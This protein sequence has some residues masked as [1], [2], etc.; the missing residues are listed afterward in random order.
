M[1]GAQYNKTQDNLKPANI[2]FYF[3]FVAERHHKK[4]PLQ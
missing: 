1:Y 4:M 2:Y 3:T